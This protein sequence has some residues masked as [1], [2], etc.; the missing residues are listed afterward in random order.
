MAGS[1]VATMVW[2]ATA[3]NIG[4]MIDGK[5]V[6]NSDRGAGVGL[7]SAAVSTPGGAPAVPCEI[8]LVVE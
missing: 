5:T 7:A 3:I 6:Q 4:S 8:S 1:A 2:S